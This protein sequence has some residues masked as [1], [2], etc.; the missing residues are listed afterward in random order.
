MRIVEVRHD[1]NPTEQVTLGYGQVAVFFCA[2]TSGSDDAAYT[3]AGPGTLLTSVDGD[4]IRRGALSWHQATTGIEVVAM[5]VSPD[6][7]GDSTFL[8]TLIVL[9]VDLVDASQMNL[10]VASLRGASSG[11]TISN[12]TT[13]NWTW[14]GEDLPGNNTV[15]SPMGALRNPD[16][17]DGVIE[18]LWWGKVPVAGTLAIIRTV[19]EGTPAVN[20]VTEPGYAVRLSVLSPNAGA[21]LGGATS[22]YSGPGGSTQAIAGSLV[23]SGPFVYLDASASRVRSHVSEDAGSL[24]QAT[25]AVAVESAVSEV[26]PWGTQLP[27]GTPRVFREALTPE[28]VALRYWPIPTRNAEMLVA[29]EGETNLGRMARVYPS[30]VMTRVADIPGHSG[31]TMTAQEAIAHVFSRWAEEFPWFEFEPVPDLRLLV[32]EAVG[33]PRQHYLD[34]PDA[35]VVTIEAIAIPQDTENRRTMREI[36]DEWLSIFPG[37]I[38]RQTSGG[39]IELVPRVGPDAPDAA[40]LQLEWRDVLEMSDGEDDPRGVINRARVESRGYK[41]ADEQAVIAPS[42]AYFADVLGL[43]PDVVEGEGDMPEDRVEVGRGVLMPFVGLVAPDEVEVDVTITVYGSHSQTSAAN[44]SVE[45][46]TS[47]TI[48]LAPG[49]SKTVSITYTSRGVSNTTTYTFTRDARGVRISNYTGLVGKHYNLFGDT[50]LGQ[51][52]TVDAVGKAWVQSNESVIAEFGSGNGDFLP[53][54]D[55]PGQNALEVSEALYGERE[56][57]IRSDVFQL[58]PEQAQAVAQGYVLFNINPRTIR[59]VRQSEWNRYPVKFDHVGRLVDLP[60]GERAV[61]ENRSY[62]DSFAPDGGFMQSAFTATV[63]ELVIDTTTE[64]LFLDN[65]EFMQLDDGTLVEAS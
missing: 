41:F 61:I 39:L 31:D 50:H 49:Q 27:P 55:D 13:N 22:S 28:D 58:T 40:A 5:G 7:P 20:Y 8:R 12:P 34:N 6:T 32:P 60:N 53:S 1:C 44:Y 46:T 26:F 63:Q 42:F 30:P 47:Q 57:T 29:V 25:Q 21:R 19:A 65:G 36:V 4:G 51:V 59:D 33:D 35:G 17:G 52:V 62:S 54:V 23:F 37:T 14:G 48:T 43:S 2:R 38:V 15:A 45:G 24:F 10:S 16:N 3:A 18:L 11:V 56:A 64:Y 9:D